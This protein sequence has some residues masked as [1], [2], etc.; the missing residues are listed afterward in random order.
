MIETGTLRVRSTT[1][2]NAPDG[3]RYWGWSSLNAWYL[4]ALAKG[5]SLVAARR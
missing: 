4:V 3:R 5:W 1:M 2:D